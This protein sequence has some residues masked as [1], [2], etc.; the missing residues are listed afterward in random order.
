MT[1]R[2][3][4]PA[5]RSVV[6]EAEIVTG[7]TRGGPTFLTLSTPRHGGVSPRIW[8]IDGKWGWVGT[9]QV[10]RESLE[11]LGPDIRAWLGDKWRPELDIETMWINAVRK[12]EGRA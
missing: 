8:Y 5:A 1:E 2:E 11:E 9:R 4:E 6:L 7:S 10:L 3:I 12:H